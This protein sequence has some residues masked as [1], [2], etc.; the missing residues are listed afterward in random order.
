MSAP[1]ALDQTV[2]AAPLLILAGTIVTGA[3]G[4]MATVI[5]KRMSR[6]GEDATARRTEVEAAALAEKALDDDRDRDIEQMR[7]TVDFAW[8]TLDRL[9]RQ[10]SSY[11]EQIVRERADREQQF[12]KHV[13]ASQKQFD[14]LQELADRRHQFVLA[15]VEG[16]RDELASTRGRIRAHRPWDE[17]IARVVRER[18]DK[19][20][21][22]PP[23]L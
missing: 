20:F 17:Q 5:V 10:V 4:F 3:L 1:L 9:T 22:D 14:G 23:D 13:E 18:V 7:K 12:A 8:S 2:W 21:P 6:R 16:L 15:E 11:E 19:D